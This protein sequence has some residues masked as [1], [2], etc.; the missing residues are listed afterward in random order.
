MSTIS[1]STVKAHHY[2]HFFDPAAMRFFASR[3]A[4]NAYLTADENVA[5]FI[6]SEQF[7][8]S[9]GHAQMRRYT[10]RKINM[11]TGSIDT[12][13]EFQQYASNTAAT[14][15]AKRLAGTT[16]ILPRV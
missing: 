16:G 5:Y 3:V 9:D 6:T 12:V 7:T 14:R 1:I 4:Q 2:G 13:G 11:H 8:G 10:V 15:E